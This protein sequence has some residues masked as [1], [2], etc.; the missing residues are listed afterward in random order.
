MSAAPRMRSIFF[1]FFFFDL[2]IFELYLIEWAAVLPI[3]LN[4]T[5]RM[6]S[7]LNITSNIPEKRLYMSLWH[8]SFW[9]AITVTNTTPQTITRVS[10]K[11]ILIKAMILSESE[12]QKDLK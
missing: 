11:S 8:G 6:G 7:I 9:K 5:P 4:N 3:E 1:F 2:G 12:K 10:K